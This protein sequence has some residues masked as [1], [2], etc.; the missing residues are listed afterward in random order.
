MGINTIMSSTGE[1]T[2]AHLALVELLRTIL[3]WV[4]VESGHDMP[5]MGKPAVG[6]YACSDDGGWVCQ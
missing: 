3:P 5:T 4:L 6:G 1:S 2:T